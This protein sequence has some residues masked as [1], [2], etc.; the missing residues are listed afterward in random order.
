MAEWKTDYPFN[1]NIDDDH[2]RHR[3]DC[4]DIFIVQFSGRKIKNKDGYSCLKL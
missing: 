2:I 3:S 4:I 1:M